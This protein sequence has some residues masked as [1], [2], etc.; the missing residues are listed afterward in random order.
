MRSKRSTRTGRRPDRRAATALVVWAT[1]FA[2]AAQADGITLTA[3][4][5]LLVGDRPAWR[6]T[7]LAPRAEVVVET[8]RSAA[9]PV[10]SGTQWSTVHPL[11]HA[12]ARF[13]AD[14]TG[15]LDLDRAVPIDG[16]Y[17]GA[18]PRGL[19]WSGVVVDARTDV[20]ADLRPAQDGEVQVLVRA[21]D[22]IVARARV[23]LVTHVDGVQ[24]TRVDTPALTGVFAAPAQARGAPVVIL[25]HGSEGGTFEDAEAE[26]SLYA[27]QGFAA[28]ALIYFSWPY[29]HVP[30]APQGFSHLPL[31]R[32]DTA[33]AWLA[34]RPEA[35][36]G[37]LALVGGSKGAEYAL[38]ASTVYPWVRAVVACVP[39]SLV[40][41]G[42]GAPAGAKGESFTLRDRPLAYVPYGDYGPVARGE[43]TSAERHRR[44]R[45][46]AAPAVVE[47]AMI[48]V[49]RSA[50]DMLLISGGRDAVWPSDAMSAELMARLGRR[51]PVGGRAPLAEWLSY[52]DAGHYLCGTG[53]SPVRFQEADEGAR[54]GGL[55]NA[56]GRDPGA[57]WERTLGFLR[58]AL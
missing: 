19:L 7:G 57:A 13:W 39:S 45:A 22:R 53:T 14:G 6:V 25:L 48:P 34:Q 41:G 12:Q 24:A 27:S 44:D 4:P 23:T 30:N 15:S 42:F 26:A 37:R 58:R 40:W 9:K 18:D 21:Q 17:S 31:E 16:T 33:R 11:F 51:G 3:R 54:G 52:P 56:D 49:E 20:P 10:Q 5:R 50:A 28:F 1:L 43:I 35:D 36:T 47:A 55:V 29:A 2:T 32:I 8:Y 38:A 46:A